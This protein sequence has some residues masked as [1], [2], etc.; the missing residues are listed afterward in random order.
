MRINGSVLQWARKRAETSAPESGFLKDFTAEQIEAW[1]SGEVEPTFSQAINLSKKLGI[2]FGYLFLSEKP[3]RSL[4]LPDLRTVRGEQPRIP[5]L[6]MMQVVDDAIRK[7]HW[8]SDLL[9]EQQRKP[10]DFVGS[11]SLEDKPDRVAADIR[12]RLGID[13]QMRAE[14]IPSASAFLTELVRR[15]ES[16]GIVVLRSGTVCGNTHRVLNVHEFRGFALPDPIAPMIFINTKDVQVAQLFTWAHEIA[17]IWLNSSGVSLLDFSRKSK[18]QANRIEIR[19]NEIA[20]EVLVPTASFVHSWVKHLPADT[21]LQILRSRYRVSY[22][23]VLRKAYDI[24]LVSESEFKAGLQKH[25]ETPLATKLK[26]KEGKE[27]GGGDFY[28]SLYARN[29]S[30]LTASVA[31]GFAAGNVLATEACALL[32]VRLTVLGKLVAT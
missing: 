3:K 6:G 15:S 9:K 26:K 31:E 20:A 18:D 1:E 2:P 10:L 17:H 7:Q 4:S 23:V 12:V 19:C 8:Y 32:G 29:S 21:N 16:K 5:S 28:N 24:G 27:K 22:L 25:Y 13:E 14:T 30:V 11:F